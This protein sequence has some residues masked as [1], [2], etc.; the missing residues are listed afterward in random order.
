MS[1]I[2]RS[3]ANLRARGAGRV[4]A[5]RPNRRRGRRLWTVEALEARALLSTFTVDSLGDA[6]AGTGLRG[7]LRYVITQV[8]RAGGD[9]TIDFAVTGKIT[10]GGGFRLPA[11]QPVAGKISLGGGFRLPAAR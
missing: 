5:R 2:P 9:N 8:D 3:S 4:L 7:D 11:S 1:G 6:G 10:L